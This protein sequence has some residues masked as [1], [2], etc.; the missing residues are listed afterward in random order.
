[1]DKQGD[2]A[3]WRHVFWLVVI[4]LALVGLAFLLPGDW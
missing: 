2:Q 4:L 3:S 1:M